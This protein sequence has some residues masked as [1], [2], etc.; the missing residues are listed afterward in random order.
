[1]PRKNTTHKPPLDLSK[2][3]TNGF[4]LKR[5]LDREQE[6][7]VIK[8]FK[9]K[10]V[11]VDS[12]SGSGKTNVLT[13][14]MKALKDHDYIERVYYVVFPVQEESLGYLPGGIPDKIKEYAVPFYQALIKAGVNPQHLDIERMCDEFFEDI[15]YKVVPHTYLRG[16]TIENVG[17]IIDEAQNGT[18]D[19]LQKTFTRLDDSCYIAIAGHRGQ[20]DI[21]NSGFTDYIRHF[22]IGKVTGAYRDIEFA[23][24][25]RNYRGE[26]SAFADKIGEFK[27]DE[28]DEEQFD[29]E[30]FGYN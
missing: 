19:E 17:V 23:K 22:K 21:E 30:Y 4:P 25:T 24:L 16:R 28:F 12:I 6:D 9:S 29:K 27:N 26:F 15:D 18:E 10:R 3:S 13:Q 1:M 7:M 5:H 14:A 11:V 20:T 2:L 8:L